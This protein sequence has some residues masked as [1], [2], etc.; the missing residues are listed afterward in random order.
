MIEEFSNGSRPLERRPIHSPRYLYM[1]ARQYW[2]QTAQLSVKSR[3]IREFRIAN[4][5][6]RT[7][8]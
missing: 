3:R 5:H 7:G 2:T 1:R 8:L 6:S 4:I